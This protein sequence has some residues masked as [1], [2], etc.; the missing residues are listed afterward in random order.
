MRY[1]EIIIYG[2]LALIYGTIA[3]MATIALIAT[4]WIYYGLLR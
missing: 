3:L 1:K 4:L 2:A